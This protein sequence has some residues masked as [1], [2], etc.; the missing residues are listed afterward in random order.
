MQLTRGKDQITY[1]ALYKDPQCHGATFVTS[2]VGLKYNLAALIHPQ[3]GGKL[4]RANM[5]QNNECA[6]CCYLCMFIVLT[7]LVINTFLEPT[8]V[9]HFDVP[10]LNY[11]IEMID[12]NN[13]DFNSTMVN[14]TV[15][16]L[17]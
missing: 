9:G 6:T 11:S 10:D 14:C 8:I 2:Q 15:K 12:T 3:F 5:S 17:S 16:I 13:S 1:S 7:I 4:L